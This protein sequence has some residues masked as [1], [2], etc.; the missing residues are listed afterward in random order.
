[1]PEPRFRSRTLRRVKRKLPSGETVV[2]YEKRKPRLGVCS[3]TGEKLK[4][5]PRERPGKMKTL[6]KSQ[7]RPSRPFGGV[8]SSR[9]MRSKIK[10][11]AREE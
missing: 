10:K 5:V 3:V 7:K 9:A 2:H 11:A 1:M 6:G 4:G 8:L